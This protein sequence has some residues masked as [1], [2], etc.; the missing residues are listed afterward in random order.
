MTSSSWK[1]SISELPVVFAD[2]TP[3]AVIDDDGVA[4][5]DY[6]EA[7]QTAFGYMRAILQTNEWSLRTLQL[8]ATCLPLN[9]ANYTVWH[10][11]R[12]CLEAVYHPT[13]NDASRWDY[14]QAD[15]DLAASLGG[16]NPKNYQI[17]YHR[18]ALL[19]RLDPDAFATFCV[20]ELE[21]LRSVLALDGKNYHAWSHRQ[22]VVATRRDEA[23]WQ[24]EVDLATMLIQQDVRNNSAWNHRWFVT[25]RGQL[26]TALSDSAEAAETEY[27]LTAAAVD[28]YNESSWRYFLAVLKEQVFHLE[29]AATVIT[30]LT[31]SEN[32]MKSIEAAHLLTK[33]DGTSQ[34]SFHLT[35][36]LIQILEWKGD[37]ESRREAIVL[38]EALAN[39]HDTIRQAYWNFRIQEMQKTLDNL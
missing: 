11:R 39:E 8:T 25:H 9:P 27:A 24:A 32:K 10:F 38:A 1:F 6:S 36:T 5:I 21:Y 4:A 19:E 13:T 22:W 35:S 17:W 12:L 20:S 7:F 14:I 15:L 3:V 29:D 31:T 28:P 2:V 34:H 23:V 37:S 26:A 30:L 33:E 16:E 18:R